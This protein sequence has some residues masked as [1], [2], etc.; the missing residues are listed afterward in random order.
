MPRQ[1]DAM[2]AEE[3]KRRIV[4]YVD[5]QKRVTVQE[6]CDEFG[7][8]SAT[9]RN[10]LNQ[11]YENGLLK[12]THGGAI[13][14]VQTNF[15]LITNEKTARF[16]NEKRAIAKEALRFVH[17]G[18][19][20]ALDAGTTILETARLLGGFEK[21]RVLTYD[22][23]IAAYLDANTNVDLYIAG[24]Q[25]RRGHHYMIGSASVEAFAKLHV[26]VFLMSANGVDPRAGLTTPQVETAQIKE[27][28]IRNAGK[29]VL[30]ADSSKVG[31]ISFAKFA[32]LSDVDVLI[33]DSYADTQ[34]IDQIRSAGTDVQIVEAKKE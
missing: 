7:V 31:N 29:R 22:L 30:L 12:R 1:N 3:R 33:T 5:K 17:E 20:I 32:D 25:V 23:N 19:C 28:I 34:I 9:I 10:D 2:F 27:G 11:L 21:L 16:M 6:L 4:A 18:D 26:D 8:S 14:N 15:E 13:A 24:G